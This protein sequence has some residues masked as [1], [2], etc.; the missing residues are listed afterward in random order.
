MNRNLLRA[1]MLESGVDVK[2]ICEVCGI[3]YP[4]F[5]RK[6]N[7]HT[8]WT[9]EE[10]YQIMDL[11]GRPYTDLPLLF[12]RRGKNEEGRKCVRKH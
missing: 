11:L 7:A 5:Y 12:P 1:K 9:L 2:T 8:E 10:C 4:S 3:S 6:L